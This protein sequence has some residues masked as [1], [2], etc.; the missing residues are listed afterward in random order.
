M[1]KIFFLI[2]ILVFS[3]QSF[4]QISLNE[5]FEGVAF[6]PEEWSSVNVSGNVSWGRD[7][8]SS[9][10]GAAC[11]SV[12][13]FPSSSYENWLITPKLSVEHSYDS[14]SFY[15]KSDDYS[16]A[17]LNVRISTTDVDTSSF[18]ETALLT[19]S[20]G[21]L[22]SSWVRYAIDLSDYNGEEIYIAFQVIDNYG[23]RIML[24]D[25][26]GP[27][28]VFPSCPKPFSLAVSN[29]TDAS[30]D[31]TWI[32]PLENASSWNLQYM[33]ASY[34]SWD[35]ATTQVVQTNPY[36]ITGITE[37]TSYKI[38]MQTNCNSQTSNWTTPITITT[39]C[40]ALSVP[41]TLET[42][43]TV[44]PSTCW[45]I[46][47]GNLPQSGQITLTEGNYWGSIPY[48]ICLGCGNSAYTIIHSTYNGWLISPS[49][50]LGTDGITYQVEMDVLLMAFSGGYADLTGSDDVFGIVVSTDNGA[51]WSREN[52]I[53]WTNEQG[54]TRALSEL[55]PMKHLSIP[56][57]DANNNPYQ[58][59][60]KIG[61]YAGST[62]DNTGYNTGNYLFIDNFIIPSCATPTELEVSNITA[63]SA[64]ISFTSDVSSS[65]NLQYTLATNTSWINATTQVVQTNP[66]TLTNL[67]PSSI[68]K[69]RMQSDCSN[70]TSNWTPTIQFETTCVPISQLPYFNNFD[71]EIAGNVP[72]CWTRLSTNNYPYV[73]SYPY[74]THSGANIIYSQLSTT[75][76]E[77]IIATP[78][79]AQDINSLKIKFWAARGYSNSNI[80]VGVMSDLGDLSTIEFVDTVTLSTT[81]AEYEVAFNG[82]ELTGENNYI[83]LKAYTTGSTSYVYVDDL[84]VDLIPSC[85]RPTNL[86][87]SNL[88]SNSFDLSW[89]DPLETSSYWNIQYMLASNPSWDNATM[90]QVTTNPYNITG[91]TANTSYK[92]RIQTDC[93]GEQS[94]WTV[95]IIITTACGSI[96]QLPYFNN[97]D[98]ESSG[99]GTLPTCWTKLSTGAYPY[100]YNYSNYAHSGSNIIYSYLSTNNESIIATPAFAQDIHSLR[101]KFWAKSYGNA[102]NNVVVGVASDLDDLSTI[103]MVDTITLT[104]TYTEYEVMFNETELTGTNRY[105]IFEAFTTAYSGY[106]Y[107][108]D[109]EVSLIPSCL[110]PTDLLVSNAT[111]TSV[112]FSWVDN[113]A[114]SW[115]IQYML[116]SE[117]SWTN[118]TNII[119]TTNPYT[120]TSLTDNTSYKIRIQAICDSEDQSQWS[121]S[122]TFLTACNNLSV[123][124]TIETFNNVP[125]TACWT[126]AGGALPQSGTVTFTGNDHWESSTTEMYQGGGNNALIHVYIYANGWLI[127]PSI[128]LGTDGTMSQVEMDVLLTDWNN[129]APQT[130]GYD[131]IFG[132]VVSTDNGLSWNR[133][134]AIL[135]TNEQ[136]ATR[137]FNNFYPMQHLTIPLKDANNNPYQGVVKIG[138]YVGSTLLNASNALHVDNF[139]V[140]EIPSCPV[141]TDFIVSNRTTTSVDI[142]WNNLSST[143]SLWDIEYKLVGDTSWSGAMQVTATTNPYTITNLLPASEYIF[144]IKASCSNE[145]S[146]WSEQ[147]TFQTLCLPANVPWLE[148]FNSSPTLPICFF[149]VKGDVNSISQTYGVQNY[150]KFENGGWA[151]TP[152]FA[153][154]ISLLKVKFWA[155]AQDT[156]LSGTL[157]V[158]IMSDPN[159]TTTFESIYT[160]QHP[161]GASWVEYEVLFNTAGTIGNNNYIAFKQNNNTN[162]WWLIE[163][164]AV[165]YIPMCPKPN[166]IIFRNPNTTS[167]DVAWS[168]FLGNSYSWDIQYMLASETSW[169]NAI[170]LVVSDN[171]YTITELAVNTSY[172]L[173]IK[174]S[175]ANEQSQWSDQVIFQTNCVALTD[176]PWMETFDETSTSSFPSCWKRFDENATIHNF[177]SVS[178]PNS[179]RL[180]SL[181]SVITPQIG[182]ELNY[183][184]LKFMALSQSVASSGSLTLGVIT[185]P[186]DTTTFESVLTIDPNYGNTWGEYNISFDTTNVSGV[187]KYIAFKQTNAASNW[188]WLLDDLEI[189]YSETSNCI[190]PTSLQVVPSTTSATIYWSQGANET[191]WQVKLG[192]TGSIIDV[193]TLS[194]QFTGL[195]LNTPYIAY[196]RAKC[197]NIFSAWQSIEFTLLPDPPTAIT[198]TPSAVSQFSAI[199]KGDYENVI[200]APQSKGFE[201]KAA[202]SNV[203][204]VVSTVEGEAPFYVNITNL[205]AD[206]IYVY[207]AFI[208]LTNVGTIYGEEVSFQT[209]AIVPPI[210]TTLDVTNITEISAT[211]TG[212]VTQG[213]EE[214]FA[215]GFE[216]KTSLQSWDESYVLSAQG[217]SPFTLTYNALIE[218]ENYNI[219][220]YV[221]TGEYGEKVTYG[222]IKNFIAT[223]E[224]QPN[225]IK[226][227][228]NANNI[229]VALY[230]NPAEKETKLF[231]SGI[232]SRV[233]MSLTDVQGRIINTQTIIVNE[234]A[235]QV[236]DL[237]NLTKGVYYLK[238]QGENINRT[239][240]LI[241]K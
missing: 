38:R 81:Y 49:I 52:A 212:I 82:T 213:T 149:V 19:L 105:I 151:T 83:V 184:K 46:A 132:I 57:K 121:N 8:Y 241:V 166:N 90:L 157:S 73:H 9:P 10:M 100:V 174:A 239:Q 196:V 172:K 22:T 48:E 204:N 113:I 173:R 158:G 144:R 104:T 95:P 146:N 86:T 118:A 139:V 211:F 224:N 23:S 76:N 37:N 24:D 11:A 217:A 210:V 207:K 129:N 28:I 89:V 101:I 88:N 120:I 16:S 123:P 12:N 168:D 192:T 65:W 208:V 127:S 2:A 97:F 99:S 44:T 155:Q 200:S 187:G 103:E 153:E 183:L 41:T 133:E 117:T 229:I 134:N 78:A 154:D 50:D 176:F 203:W 202:Y 70:Q 223:S 138:I 201:Y 148:N 135:W 140:R 216:L 186:F 198:L 63:T 191:S 93:G 218:N 130:D 199:L 98:N 167:I 193:N 69:I 32:D 226:E 194:Y 26:K 106:A 20:N 231:I 160:I 42:F 189:S 108:D 102:I 225:G 29:L 171:P 115:N 236:L 114:T 18:N 111:T 55:Y 126:K 230:P 185:D 206:S 125:P 75:N 13:I 175:C 237:S 94:E 91:L 31:L 85:A 84:T 51:T 47:S 221:K 53:L 228:N 3:L 234:K 39:P 169:D 27:N 58:G 136:G 40:V 147:I 143:S 141:P 181:T 122:I 145:Q 214:L 152:A 233:K 163:N 1:K 62:E 34:T 240:K 110:I 165:D 219:K 33:L 195:T 188:S 80:A 162:N 60:V 164:V 215:R 92:I 159:D 77:S 79:F 56:L 220:A 36:T 209:L 96:S 66:Y 14:I 107:I 235:E 180:T 197:E 64:D 45:S 142:S 6:P 4:S 7:T 112:D 74:H 178:S 156:S 5:G 182:V 124:T 59:I 61:I 67:A 71:S 190:P 109:V 72:N 30:I 232:N 170:T 177:Q 25:V 87:V 222:E 68:Y 54:A 227:V 137:R 43:D 35:Y 119:A 15:I 131:D 238:L 21:D 128:D 205:Y 17:T 116:A 179:L 161:S 150:L